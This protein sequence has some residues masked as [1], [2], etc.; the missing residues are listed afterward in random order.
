MSAALP[1]PLITILAPALAILRAIASPMPLVDP[2]TTAVL[3]LRSVMNAPVQ[4]LP[5]SPDHLRSDRR[6]PW[7]DRPVGAPA[8]RDGASTCARHARRTPSARSCPHE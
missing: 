8:T 3:P 6:S 2:V 7:F 1:M 4:C 5:V